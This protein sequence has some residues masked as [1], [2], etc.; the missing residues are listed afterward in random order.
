MNRAAWVLTGEPFGP[1]IPGI[2]KD[3]DAL[4]RLANARM[5]AGRYQGELLLD[6]PPEYVHWFAGHGRTGA[7]VD[8][9][10][11][12]IY[13]MRFNGLEEVLR[14]LV[15]KRENSESDGGDNP[16]GLDEDSPFPD[17]LDW[18]L[19]FLDLE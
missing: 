8:T 3:P 14:A 15:E 1:M 6:L 11:A 2:E 16:A 17:E 9:Q 13:T 19:A 12:A 5:P 4:L 10:L 18:M 7:V